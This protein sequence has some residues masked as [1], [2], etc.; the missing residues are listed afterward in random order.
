[1]SDPDPQPIYDPDKHP[2]PTRAKD[3]EALIAKRIG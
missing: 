2:H 1:M 3:A